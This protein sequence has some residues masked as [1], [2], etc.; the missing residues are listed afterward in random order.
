M[1]TG[2]AGGVAV[3]RA[4]ATSAKRDTERERSESWSDGVDNGLN[5]R[6]STSRWPGVVAVAAGVPF[7]FVTF[8]NKSLRDRA[9][10]V[11]PWFLGLRSDPGGQR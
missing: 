6:S 8:L 3:A 11:G 10:P 4:A 9:V 1:R 7:F 5:D 2:G